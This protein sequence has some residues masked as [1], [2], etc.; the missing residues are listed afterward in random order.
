MRT[1]STVNR[2]QATIDAVVC[3]FSDMKPTT[4][5]GDPAVGGGD[6]ARRGMVAPWVV[7]PAA[8][9]NFEQLPGIRRR[10]L[11]RSTRVGAP[12]RT[13]TNS[14]VASLQVSRYMRARG[15]C[16]RRGGSSNADHSARPDPD[17][18]RP[19]AVLALVHAV[20]VW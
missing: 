12:L 15:R 10:R 9:I 11:E 3:V 4:C 18:T 19:S 16:V 14:F 13:G 17:Q 7:R 2:S 1:A 5:C 20:H 6:S 8:K